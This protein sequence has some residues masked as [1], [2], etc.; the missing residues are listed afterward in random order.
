MDSLKGKNGFWTKNCA[1]TP[2]CKQRAIF[3]PPL[4]LRERR[5]KL[6]TI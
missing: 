4:Q 6:N 5:Q 1:G 2:R 3:S